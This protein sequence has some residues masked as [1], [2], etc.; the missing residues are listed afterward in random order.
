MTSEKPETVMDALEAALERARVELDAADAVAAAQITQRFEAE[1]E[2]DQARADLT[3]MREEREM[4]CYHLWPKDGEGPVAAARRL[5]SDLTAAREQ[6]RK[7]RELLA[8]CAD[9]M[10]RA[11]KILT[12]DGSSWNMLDTANARAFLAPQ[13]QEPPPPATPP[14]ERVCAAC[15]SE[16]ADPGITVCE[17]CWNQQYRPARKEPPPAEPEARHEFVPC[18]EDHDACARACGKPASGPCHATEP[19]AET[20]DCTDGCGK[21]HATEPQEPGEGKP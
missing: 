17:H 2:R 7:A 10:E 1:A 14:T 18:C 15:G 12:G 4:V 21:W 3:A 16:P 8:D 6:E 5:H 9:R 19:Q 13:V 11:R 20:H